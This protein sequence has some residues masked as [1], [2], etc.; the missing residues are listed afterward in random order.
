MIHLQILE[1]LGFYKPLDY[2]HKRFDRLAKKCNEIEAIFWSAGYFEL[3]KYGILTPQLKASGYRLDFGLEGEG[4]KVTIEIDGHDYHKTK[5]QRKAD[6]QR[7]RNL[8]R[9]GWRF[10][11]FT[12]GDIYNDV[13]GC[14]K[15]VVGIVRAY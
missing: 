9:R 8:K 6:Y 15:E 7:E 1:R 14:V 2:D 13:Q 3:S 4:F 10:I 12:G 5:E 11:R